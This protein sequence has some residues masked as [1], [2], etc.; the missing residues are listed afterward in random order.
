MKFEEA[1]ELLKDGKKVRRTD[2]RRVYSNEPSRWEELCYIRLF[3][4]DFYYGDICMPIGLTY[5]D[6]MA[7]DWE[8]YKEPLLTKEEKEFL[9]MVVKM[10]PSNITRFMV[11]CD[12]I[13]KRFYLAFAVNNEPFVYQ[14]IY[15]NNKY[16]SNLEFD[17]E[18]TLE[19]LGLND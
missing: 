13:Q 19:E 2:T 17:K 11:K 18:Y 10:S 14:Y 5:S 9:K 4:N 8:E 3:C 12:I 16:F 7:D 1:L 15:V 6:I